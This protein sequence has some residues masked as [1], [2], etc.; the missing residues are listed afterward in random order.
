MHPMKASPVI[1]KQVAPKN[2]P[3]P[4]WLN[5]RG[6]SQLVGTSPS[7]RVTVY[8]DPSLGPSALQNAQ[9]LVSDA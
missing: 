1:G 2:P 3:V 5:Y 8:V 9:D 6:V 7:G 4:N